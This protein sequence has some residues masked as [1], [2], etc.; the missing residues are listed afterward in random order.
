MDEFIQALHRL[1]DAT[2][3]EE[4]L[5]ALWDLRDLAFDRP[6]SWAPLTADTLLQALAEAVED[7]SADDRRDWLI[8]N[9]LLAH[10]FE[11]LL[12]RK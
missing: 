3:R 5:D 4:I 1:R 10:A 2:A 11:K 7:M 6:G 9:R 8:A 12:I